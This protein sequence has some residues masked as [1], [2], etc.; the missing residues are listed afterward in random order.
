LQPDPF[1]ICIHAVDSEIRKA[2]PYRPDQRKNINSQQ[3][4]NCWRNEDPRYGT[5]RQAFYSLRNIGRG[6]LYDT[7]H[8][9]AGHKKIPNTFV[10][11]YFK[12]QRA[13]TTNW[14]EKGPAPIG[15][16]TTSTSYSGEKRFQNL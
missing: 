1:D 16:L 12:Q 14:N 8:R 4:K 2:Q 5:I 6:R 15:S 11:P 7:I 10:G 13:A 9:F 3:Q